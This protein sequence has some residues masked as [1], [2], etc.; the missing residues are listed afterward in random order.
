MEC[1]GDRPPRRYT[2]TEATSVEEGLDVERVTVAR[3][4]VYKDTI[5]QVCWRALVSE[6]VRE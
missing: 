4:D 2:N 6:R 5:S 1:H 3:N